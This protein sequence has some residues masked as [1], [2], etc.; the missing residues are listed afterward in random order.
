LDYQLSLE[1][2]SSEQIQGYLLE[3]YTHTAIAAAVQSGR[4]DCGLGIT[5]SARAL[6]LGFIPLYT[7]IYQ[8]VV[9]SQTLETH[10]LDPVFDLAADPT[11]RKSILELPGYDVSHMGEKVAEIG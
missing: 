5:A 10:L 6:D 1:G 8:L 9:P 2:I 7:E 4:A 11:F 3:E